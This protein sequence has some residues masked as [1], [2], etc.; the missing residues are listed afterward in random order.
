VIGILLR[1]LPHCPTAV[2][3]SSMI[4]AMSIAANSVPVRLI[5]N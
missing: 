3:W 1:P 5:V 4:G 2:S